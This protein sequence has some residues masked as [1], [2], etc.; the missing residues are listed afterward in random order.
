MT[1]VGDLAADPVAFF[2]RNMLMLDMGLIEPRPE[3]LDDQHT[4]AIT[5]VDVTDGYVA[6][7]VRNRKGLSKLL[8]RCG[9]C[10]LIATSH[11][12][13]VRLAAQGEESVRAY[14]CPYRPTRRWVKPCPTPQA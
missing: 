1:A 10:E 4:C 11:I 7:R 9:I 5:L 6:T 8:A 3:D 13:S 12:Y 14:I 2:K